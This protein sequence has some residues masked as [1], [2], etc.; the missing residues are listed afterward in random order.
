MPPTET[1]TATA[2]ATEAPTAE[3]TSE[4]TPP[5]A[6][7]VEATVEIT[8]ELT[9]EATAEAPT[10]TPT[11]SETPL[12]LEPN[13]L[14]LSSGD[15]E[16]GTAPVGWLFDNSWGPQ[17]ANGNRAF[18]PRSFGGSAQFTQSVLHDAAIQMRLRLGN[19]IASFGLR[20][21]EAGGY[22]ATFEEAGFLRLYR[23]EQE[24]SQM[25]LGP[26]AGQWRTLR[27]SA[28]GD[29]VRVFLDGAELITFVDDP[30][31][32][33]GFVTLGGRRS[34]GSGFLM[35]DLS[36]WA[37]EGETVQ[38]AAARAAPMAYAAASESVAGRI[39][40]SLAYTVGR[41]V[42]QGNDQY[43]YDF[44]TIAGLDGTV[45]SYDQSP[46][47]LAGVK[48]WS[49]DGQWL[50]VGTPDNYG[51]SIFNPA[52]GS[53]IRLT[54]V[55]SADYT[56]YDSC[57]VWSPDGSRI[58]FLST[59][60]D[61]SYVTPDGYSYR[62]TTIYIV[63]TDGQSAPQRVALAA[64]NT[65]LGCPAWSSDGKALV[66]N[67]YDQIA[68]QTS[69]ISI[70]LG[71]NA[72]VREPVTI[73]GW[74]SRVIWSPDADKAAFMQPVDCGCTEQIR[75]LDL[76]SGTITEVTNNTGYSYSDDTVWGSSGAQLASMR[77]N[78]N[79]GVEELVILD[80]SQPCSDCGIRVLTE[81]PGSSLTWSPDEAWLALYDGYITLIA[82]D[83]GE[84]MLVSEDTGWGVN[85][86]AWN[87]VIAPLCEPNAVMAFGAG[88]EYCIPSTVTPTPEPTPPYDPETECLTR[89]LNW[90]SNLDRRVLEAAEIAQYSNGDLSETA[91]QETLGRVQLNVWQYVVVVAVHLNQ[92]FVQ[93]R[94]L[95]DA[96]QVVEGDRWVRV[97]NLARNIVFEGLGMGAEGNPCFDEDGQFSGVKV[98]QLL[99]V[100]TDLPVCT[101]S[102]FVDCR[103]AISCN[104]IFGCNEDG[105]HQYEV[106]VLNKFGSTT[107][108]C[109]NLSCPR[110]P[111]CPSWLGRI[112][113]Q[114]CGTDLQTT[115]EDGSVQ[116]PVYAVESGTFCGYFPAS[117]VYF[118]RSVEGSEVWEYQYTHVGP[119]IA[120]PG[121]ARPYS[122]VASGANLG[123]YGA[124][125]YTD[126]DNLHVHLVNVVYSYSPGSL[127]CS[128]TNRLVA[129]GDDPDPYRA[130]QIP[131]VEVE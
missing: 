96:G 37:G 73:T 120:T 129:T 49:A 89:L 51:F 76:D 60:R 4:P 6:V 23:N 116:E 57:P 103:P 64:D 5:A 25:F 105:T 77:H 13:W 54:T 98:E 83:S 27:L 74:I 11:A 35:D 16:Q 97:R 111:A 104:W 87:P 114:H 125:G 75:V 62:R 48:P 7:T 44:L 118:I 86:M 81:I 9:A 31:L 43:I 79:T 112:D 19:G 68:D 1:S 69:F 33:A 59:A 128:I 14:L 110:P 108:G 42:M 40:S 58:A 109:N 41:A 3:A 50:V 99:M 18:G 55:S 34:I 28:A 17:V 78:V 70:P 115:T 72:T 90:D 38:P 102:Q 123:D 56:A 101:E 21:S 47:S 113:D 39:T 65:L 12:P 122:Y 32:P 119:D 80:L 84:R 124:Y 22:T 130:I 26:I 121:N 106:Q 94:Y 29:G 53:T 45:T 67:R 107:G 82:A 85:A 100:E 36:V 20:Q 30:P 131:S 95:D 8:P 93:I 46:M 91:I 92:Q 63:Q 2:T 52:S 88:G 127:L 15:F 66:T 24:V 71:P 117:G 126:P 61:G 10:I